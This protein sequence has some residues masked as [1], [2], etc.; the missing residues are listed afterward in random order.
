M[1]DILKKQ[2]WFAVAA[3]ALTLIF[4][5]ISLIFYTVNISA[6]GYFKEMTA[7]GV[8]GISV[9]VIILEIV[10]LA[11]IELK[12]LGLLDKLPKIAGKAIDVAFD[13]IVV[14]IPAILVLAFLNFLDA[15][16]EG[17]AYIYF[18]DS[19]VTDVIQAD[20]LVMSSAS[21]AISGLVL[22]VV[23]A[24]LAVV[25]SFFSF[26]KKQKAVAAEAQA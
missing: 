7:K 5:I 18:S 10:V 1:K 24:V 25:A 2:P 14:V 22:Y 19:N 6:D 4:A 11:Y 12:A 9:A 3:N 23:T 20:P 26:S 17:F 16:V 8:V 15:R 21:T 13:V